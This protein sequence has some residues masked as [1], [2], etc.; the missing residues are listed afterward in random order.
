MGAAQPAVFTGKDWETASP[1]SQGVDSAKLQQALSL[2]DKT[3]GSNGVHELVIIR[4]GRMIWHRDDIDNVH[5]VWSLTEVFTMAMI[6][7]GR[8]PFPET[9]ECSCSSKER[10]RCA[11]ISPSRDPGE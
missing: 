9:A 2:L 3:V 4:N 1:E 8:S 10:T 6:V 7:T 11:W 5:G